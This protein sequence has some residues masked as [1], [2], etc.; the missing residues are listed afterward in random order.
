MR[1]VGSCYH[2]MKTGDCAV[3]APNSN[4]RV[5]TGNLW[6]CSYHGDAKKNS[7]FFLK[8]RQWCCIWGSLPLTLGSRFQFQV[9][10]G[11]QARMTQGRARGNL[12]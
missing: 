11:Q 5:V 3:A 9:F 2:K 4:V 1:A 10:I 8:M 7:P 6:R 12:Q